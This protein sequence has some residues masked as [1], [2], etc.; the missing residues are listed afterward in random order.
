MKIYRMKHGIVPGT[1]RAFQVLILAGAWLGLGSPARAAS[2]ADC[3]ARQKSDVCF[4]SVS[5]RLADGRDLEVEVAHP[6]VRAKGIIAFSHGAN[7]APER[8]RALISAWAIGGYWVLSPLHLDSERHPH[9]EMHDRSRILTTRLADF[10]AVIDAAAGEGR[11]SALARDLRRTAKLPLFAAGHSY[12][13][14]IAQIAGGASVQ[15]TSDTP[16]TLVLQ[17][18]LWGVIALSPPPSAVGF[19][20]K[21][22]WSRMAVPMLVE[23]GTADIL[24]PFVA[25]WQQHLDSHADAPEGRSWA[26]VYD[27]VDHY[28]GGLIGRPVDAPE[29]QVK[30]QLARFTQLSLRFMQHASAATLQKM[31]TD[32]QQ[33]SD[34]PASR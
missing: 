10:Q 14:Y 24:P 28:F 16:L 19:S 1:L 21:G 20:P 8:Y 13:A 30:I 2:A 31:A 9:R 32:I 22:S 25:Q 18:R 7:A 23:T 15:D 11:N 4:S 6:G 27:H 17:P 34:A 29:P 3:Q 5:M 33:F 26:A 12:G